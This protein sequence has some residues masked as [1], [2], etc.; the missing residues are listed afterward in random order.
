MDHGSQTP[1]SQSCSSGALRRPRAWSIG[2][3]HVHQPLLHV[4]GDLPTVRGTLDAAQ[5]QA[6]MV[7]AFDDR[8][9]QRRDN[10]HAR[11]RGQLSQFHCG[12]TIPTASAHEPKYTDPPLTGRSRQRQ[13][14]AAAA[15]DEDLDA[16]RY[17]VLSYSTMVRRLPSLSQ[18]FLSAR[19]R[20]RTR[21]LAL[22]GQGLAAVVGRSQCPA[23]PARGASRRGR[24]PGVAPAAPEGGPPYWVEL[25]W[26]CWRRQP[27]VL[28]LS[29]LDGMAPP[30][31]LMMT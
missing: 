22:A 5:P 26:H 21:Q 15:K 30:A 6:R 9:E 19:S 3:T 13:L 25:V 23:W 31:N 1:T 29:T 16:H 14:G 28:E 10:A 12:D 11:R 8:L 20:K 24:H 7:D 27:Q 2:R 4:G 17:T 18:R